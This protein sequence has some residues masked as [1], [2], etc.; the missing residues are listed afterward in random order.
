MRRNAARPGPGAAAG[1]TLL[2]SLVAF[3]IAAL[4]LAAM[5]QVFARGITAAALGEEYTQALAIAETRLA[6]L[7]LPGA[8]E[9]PNAGGR[10]RD[11]YQWRTTIRDYHGGQA[12]SAAPR[13]PLKAVSVTVS[14][15]HRGTG[16]SITLDTLKPAAPAPPR[17]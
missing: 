11:K 10:E 14:W 9:R 17:P 15:K 1:V 4:A 3:S 5:F 8:L 13:L 12:A 16:K 2:E 6:L 7:A